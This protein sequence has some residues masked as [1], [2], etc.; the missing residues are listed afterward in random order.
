VLVSSATPKF[1][2]A[3][4]SNPLH[5]IKITVGVHT[6]R[7]RRNKLAEM[8]IFVWNVWPIGPFP[9][10]KIITQVSD[11]LIVLIQNRHA[12]V[13]VGNVKLIPKLVEATRIA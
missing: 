5:H 9:D 3:P 12:S 8:S 1:C 6:D 11:E 7:V 4:I 2:N 10:V 13:E